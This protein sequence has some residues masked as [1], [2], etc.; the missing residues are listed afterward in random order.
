MVEILQTIKSYGFGTEYVFYSRH[1]KTGTLS[2]NALTQALHRMGYK[3]RMTGH[4]FR[5]LASTAL[6]QMQYPHKAIELQLAHADGNEVEK[7][8]NEADQLPI[9]IEMMN[10]WANIVDEIKQ[11]NFD[12]YNRRTTTDLSTAGIEKLFKSLGKTNSEITTELSIKRL[13]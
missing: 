8:Y 5:G 10:D 13:Q 4:G 1:T 3:G 2:E 7:A 9:R 12:T 6:N 11:G